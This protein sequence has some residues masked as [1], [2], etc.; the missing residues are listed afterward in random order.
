VCV[1]GAAHLSPGCSLGIP[2]VSSRSAVRRT[3][4]TM[5][6]AQ[7]CDNRECQASELGQRIH[8]RNKHPDRGSNSAGFVPSRRRPSVGWQ[9][10]PRLGELSRR[11]WRRA[12]GTMPR[13]CPAGRQSPPRRVSCDPVDGQ[14]RRASLAL[15]PRTS[16]APSIGPSESGFQQPDTRFAAAAHGSTVPVM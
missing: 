3:R 13:W 7:M 5:A 4:S 1:E 10:I 14:S 15:R 9:S 6:C 2:A 8:C 11:T 12:F 16:A